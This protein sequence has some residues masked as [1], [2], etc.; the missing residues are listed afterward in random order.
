MNT[1][2][3]DKYIGTGKM[4]TE[5]REYTLKAA[6]ESAVLLK[7]DKGVLPVKGGRVAFFGRMQDCYLKSGT[8]S[9][10]NDCGKVVSIREALLGFGVELDGE[11]IALY[12]AFVK[13]H[14]YDSGTGWHHP[15]SQK[16][17]V[18][19]DVTVSAAAKRCDTAIYVIT[20]IS[21]EDRDQT[22]D[23]GSYYLSY[24]ELI[25]LSR[26]RA[27]FGRVIVLLNTC[28]AMDVNEIS[29]L[30]DGLLCLW[31]A[32]MDGGSAAA[33]LITGKANPCGKSPDTFAKTLDCYPAANYG[34]DGD[35]IYTE[36]QF[37]GYRYF[38]TFAPERVIFPF[39]YGL[40]YTRFETKLTGFEIN[41]LNLKCNFEVANVGE[42]AGSEVV[43]VYLSYPSG[44][45]AP[46]AVL[47]GFVKTSEISKGAK[48]GVTAD[49][50]LKDVTLYDD[51][52]GEYYLPQGKYTVSI[53][54]SI[55]YKAVKEFDF[56]GYSLEDKP[57]LLQNVPFERLTRF[58]TE[59]VPTCDSRSLC[60]VP[61]E[62]THIDEHITLTDVANGKKTLSEL[63]AS[64]SD[65][66]LAC[67]VRGEGMSSPK[68]AP[69]AA[70][71]FG[72]ITKELY[73]RDIPVISTTDGPAGVRISTSAVTSAIPD[74]TALAATFNPEL[75]SALLQYE[76]YEVLS[77]GCDVLLAPGINIH[78]SPL[79]GRNF[80][81][82]S[83]DPLLAGYIARAAVKGL[84]CAGV[85]GVIK[86]FM[87][88]NQEAFRYTSSSVISEKA[89]RQIYAK[90]FEIA[91]ESG[92]TYAVM[93][94]YNRIG[95]RWAANNE[96]MAN[97]L[98][99]RFDGIVMTDWWAKLGG[100][101]DAQNVTDLAAMVR[102][103]N[104]LY[105]VM[106]DALTHE[107]NITEAL[108]DG[109]LHRSELQSSA[110]RILTFIMGTVTFARQL[111]YGKK[112]TEDLRRSVE[113]KKPFAVIDFDGN[114]VKYE[115]AK[116][117]RV[118]AEIVCHADVKG[119]EQCV[120][121]LTVNTKGAAV[122]AVPAGN[123]SE[124]REVSFIKGSNDLAFTS[125]VPTSGI[126][127]IK[128]YD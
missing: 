100:C 66:E 111:K 76:G 54:D 9:G 101:E 71:V 124:Y 42:Y 12:D 105:M 32:G 103:Q 91:V 44:T 17:L 83:E 85:R 78:R 50:N 128:L 7:N 26:I 125:T 21:G 34:R 13:E 23:R 1:K 35:V 10:N 55:N 20:R 15:H 18:L 94:S 102:A 62:L 61:D 14:P 118:I 123:T 99:A 126:K 121:S 47:A 63:V 114:A 27:H 80:E 43:E 8:G 107:D 49:I 48:L 40:S 64:L 90:P 88:N 60:D 106:P 112:Q 117:Q 58:G 19:D 33:M 79:C 122:M 38:N 67:L 5:L 2:L 24:N 95:G 45:N 25:M 98:R 11:L 108:A 77:F 72:G 46:K 52:K 6:L 89:I 68:G 31:Q 110:R 97:Y 104:D 113:G 120:I 81:Y 115:S 16:E 30:C 87:A 119:L 65:I 92:E 75:V 70:S 28:A 69:G 41:G 74:G 84:N 96:P 73:D 116:A 56:G 29:P 127:Q 37:V 59:Q 93:T 82:Y 3:I 57:C 4:V 53:G 39:G 86:H 36:D 109:R 51:F 22:A